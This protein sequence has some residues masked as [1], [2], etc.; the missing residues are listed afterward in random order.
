MNGQTRIFIILGGLNSALSVALGAFGA[1]ILK[2]Y[3]PPSLMLTFQTAVRYHFFHALGL[4]AIAFVAYLIP[5]SKLVKGAGILMCA[6]IVLFP[7]S[8][9]LI[10]F[11]GIRLFGALTPIGGA[12]FILSWLLIALAASKVKVSS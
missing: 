10:C 6:G 9:Y 4:I 5:R 2:G 8:L 12:S 11:T 3:L 1:H 7:G